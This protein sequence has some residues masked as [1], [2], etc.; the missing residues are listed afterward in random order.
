[1]RDLGRLR[2][3]EPRQHRAHLRALS[4]APVPLERSPRPRVQRIDARRLRRAPRDVRVRAV[5]A[6]G[7][8][9]T[10]EQAPAAESAAAARAAERG[11][12]VELVVR[13]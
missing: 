4:V 11:A 1:M 13:L 5:R 8:P 10:V 12:P 3:A 7:A 2:L 9:T 6:V